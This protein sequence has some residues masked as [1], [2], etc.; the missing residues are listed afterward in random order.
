MRI[1]NPAGAHRVLVTKDLPGERWKEI[2]IAANCRVE[3]RAI[4]GIA[5]RVLPR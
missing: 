4:S 1:Y 5:S 2:L 3:A